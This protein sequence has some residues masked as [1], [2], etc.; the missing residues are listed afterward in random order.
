[1][2]VIPPRVIVSVSNDRAELGEAHRGP[3]FDKLRTAFRRIPSARIRM[4][5]VRRHA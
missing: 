3:T 2:M 5:L 1:M 4:T